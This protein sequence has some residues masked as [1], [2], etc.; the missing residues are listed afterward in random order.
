MVS[1]EKINFLKTKNQKEAEENEESDYTR[2][3]AMVSN[4]IQIHKE[5]K[6]Y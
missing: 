2:A 6:R 5:I 3:L 1:W 4:H